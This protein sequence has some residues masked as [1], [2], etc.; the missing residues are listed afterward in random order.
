MSV[1]TGHDQLHIGHGNLATGHDHNRS[2]LLTSR[3]VA[4]SPVI[5]G[6]G[7]VQSQLFF[8]HNDLTFKH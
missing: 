6:I 8:G 1:M 4:D 3:T 2:W 7:L 5:T